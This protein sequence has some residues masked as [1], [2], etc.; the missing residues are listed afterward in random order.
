MAEFKVISK[1]VVWSWE[2]VLRIYKRSLGWRCGHGI[3]VR[4]R[5][6]GGIFGQGYFEVGITY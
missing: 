1:V 3:N 2:V 4:F 5:E 6:G